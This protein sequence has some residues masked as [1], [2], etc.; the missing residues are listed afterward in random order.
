[1]SPLRKPHPA[2]FPVR[3]SM[4]AEK[5]LPLQGKSESSHVIQE[6]TALPA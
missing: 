5:V 1:M 2:S 4:F 6:A 3:I